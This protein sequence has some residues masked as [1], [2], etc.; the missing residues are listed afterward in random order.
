MYSVQKAKKYKVALLGDAAVGKSSIVSRFVRDEYTDSQ[1]ST[2]GAA[3]FSKL[4]VV[5]EETRES[6]FLEIWDTAGQERYHSLAPM[7]YRG[8]KLILVVF[9]MT[10]PYSVHRAKQYISQVHE[11]CPS[12]LIC[13]IGNK[14]DLQNARQVSQEHA[15]QLAQEYNICYFETSAKTGQGIQQMFQEMC[16]QLYTKESEQNTQT[17]STSPIF[18]GGAAATYQNQEKNICC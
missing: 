15:V 14:C 9:D 5:N 8:A 17:T 18:L 3:F 10:N 7:Y 2:I 1:E 12:S 16:D 6:L 11:Q 13:L 4:F